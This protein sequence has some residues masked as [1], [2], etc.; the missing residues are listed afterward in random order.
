MIEFIFGFA[1]GIFFVSILILCLSD[2]YDS[3][4]K[5]VKFKRMEE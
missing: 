3:Y 2:D 4:V 1:V 5:H